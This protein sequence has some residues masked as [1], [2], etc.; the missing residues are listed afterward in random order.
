MIILV[1]G[2]DTTMVGYNV[3]MYGKYFSI[4][5]IFL[6]ATSHQAEAQFYSSRITTTQLNRATNGEVDIIVEAETYVPS[7]YKGRAEPTSGNLIKAIAI[8]TGTDTSNMTYRW[9]VNGQPIQSQEQSVTFSAPIGN[10]FILR[11]TVIKDGMFWSDKNE[12]ISLS[13]PEVIL[14]EENALRGLGTI[15]IGKDFSLIGEEATIRAVPFFTGAQAQSNLTGNWTVDD[16]TVISTDWRKLSFVRPEEPNSRY[17]VELNIFNR[18][19]LNESAKNSFY[20]HLD[21]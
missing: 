18:L 6:I 15:A 11:V 21:I 5:I 13:R 2:F 20:L 1:T 9:S 8:P 10:N 17:F 7:F 12:T 3:R 16:Q 4:L 19:N 14:Y